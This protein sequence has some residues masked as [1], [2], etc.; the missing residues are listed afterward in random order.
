MGNTVDT[1]RPL[2]RPAKIK[3]PIDNQTAELLLAGYC[4]E[5][6]QNEQ[7]PKEIV[8]IVLTLFDGELMPLMV[9][10]H[11]F[12]TFCDDGYRD[13]DLGEISRKEID[14][15]SFFV[16]NQQKSSSDI[17]TCR[18]HGSARGCKNGKACKYSHDN[19]N[20]VP[21]CKYYSSD[22]SQKG[23]KYG[24]DCKYRH[25]KFWND[26]CED[27]SPIKF[28]KTKCSNCN[29]SDNENEEILGFVQSYRTKFDGISFGTGF[30][31]NANE[32][33]C[34]ECR[35]YTV[36]NV[37]QYVA[38]NEWNGTL[39]E[40]ICYVNPFKHNAEDSINELI[41]EKIK[42]QGNLGR[43]AFKDYTT[44]ENIIQLCPCCGK[45]EI[46]SIKQSTSY[47]DDMSTCDS[48]TR[49]GYVFIRNVFY[50]SNCQLSIHQIT[51]KYQ[52]QYYK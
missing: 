38:T 30:I 33:R 41:T 10:I 5:I 48:L 31:N 12:Q 52:S 37:R 32:Y 14:I 17:I 29:K 39:Q 18:D 24:S 13:I 9:D 15:N 20:S 26:K 49:A 47:I 43:I 45:N 2:S 34:G 50:C 27:I 1:S 28:D 3:P 35:F 7:C 16:S 8:D 22:T 19:P 4:R 42:F 40:K 21:F 11:Y 46:K 25:Q 6:A 36:F 23:C 44:F 51:P